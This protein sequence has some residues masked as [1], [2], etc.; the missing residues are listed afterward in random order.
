M[1][2]IVGELAIF[3]KHEDTPENISSKDELKE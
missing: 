3:I 1:N 2:I